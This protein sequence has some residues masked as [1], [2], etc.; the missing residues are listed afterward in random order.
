M[1]LV[2]FFR[3]SGYMISFLPIFRSSAIH[4]ADFAEFTES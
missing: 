4:R 2:N 1:R 3:D